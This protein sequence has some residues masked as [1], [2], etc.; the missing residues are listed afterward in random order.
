M[1]IQWSEEDDA[2]LVTLPEFNNALTHGNTY[3][4]AARQGR[5]LIESFI[6]WY[7]QDGK[8]LPTPNLFNFDKVNGQLPSRPLA[9][10]R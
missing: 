7:E 4:A 5:E 6:I 8:P 9:I 3:E 2:Y 1:I 10:A